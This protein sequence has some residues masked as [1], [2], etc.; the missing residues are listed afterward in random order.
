MRKYSNEEILNFN[1]VTLKIAGNYLWISSISIGIGM[2]S[3]LLPI[4]LAIHNEDKE[5]NFQKVGHTIS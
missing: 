2:R 1:K 4:G 5:T 3:N